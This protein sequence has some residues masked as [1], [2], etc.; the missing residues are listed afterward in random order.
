M[1]ECSPFFLQVAGGD[2]PSHCGRGV[3][4]PSNQMLHRIVSGQCVYVCVWVGGGLVER[5]GVKRG[6]ARLKLNCKMCV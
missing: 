2:D 4:D 6:L 3:S 1:F 5:G